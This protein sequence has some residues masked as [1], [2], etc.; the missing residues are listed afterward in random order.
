[1]L[2]VPPIA[3]WENCTVYVEPAGAC[4]RSRTSKVVKLVLSTVP[5]VLAADRSSATTVI[6]S[7]LLPRLKPEGT[8]IETTRVSSFGSTTVSPHVVTVKVVD[9]A[10]LS[11]RIGPLCSC[12]M[13]PWAQ[14]PRPLPET[15]IEVLLETLVS[16]PLTR[17]STVK[18]MVFPVGESPSFTEFVLARRLRTGVDGD[19]V[20]GA[21]VAG[22]VVGVAVVVGA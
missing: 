2:T 20:G 6:V 15:V 11:I 8:L 10:F 21:V 18:V 7:E 22:A 12:A 1:V 19:V 9:D 13:A 17:F 3:G 16:V 5:E 14:L 4:T